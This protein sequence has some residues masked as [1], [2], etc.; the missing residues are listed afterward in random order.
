[1]NSYERYKSYKIATTKNYV[2]HQLGLIA[3][4][5]LYL[6]PGI[7]VFLFL[8]SLIFSYFEEW[9]YSVSLYYSFVTLSTI[10]FGDY[11]PTFVSRQVRIQQSIE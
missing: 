11:V 2:P 3:Q 9:D 7:V 1:M 10:G 5:I 6:I 8:P 4:I